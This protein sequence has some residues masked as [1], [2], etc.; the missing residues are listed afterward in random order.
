MMSQHKE[1]NMYTSAG[2][3]LTF[4]SALSVFNWPRS[5]NF[6]K[7]LS[8]FKMRK[9]YYGRLRLRATLR[10]SLSAFQ[11]FRFS[12]PLSVFLKRSTEA[13]VYRFAG[14]QTKNTAW[15]FGVG[16]SIIRIRIG[17]RKR[18][19]IDQPPAYLTDNVNEVFV[20]QLKI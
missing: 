18:N 19:R 8:L 4:R 16:S 13:V 9:R 14:A 7:F 2:E 10:S 3:F 20:K 5:A 15:V 17:I 1:V 12:F 11:F 6:I